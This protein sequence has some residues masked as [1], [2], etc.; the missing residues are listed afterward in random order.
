M[1]QLS[2]PVRLF[3]K[4]SLG[5]GTWRVHGLI[6]S[7]SAGTVVIAHS[8]VEGGAEITHTDPIR[9]NNSGRSIEQQVALEI[10]SRVKRQMDKGYKTT[11]DLALIGSTNQLGLVNPM[12]AQKLQDVT[13]RG[14]DFADAWLQPKYD[15]HRCLITKQGGEMLAYSRRGKPITTIPQILEDCDRWMQDGDT[16][17]GELYCHGEKL[18][19][20]S[21]WIKRDQPETAKL[22][23]HWYDMVLPWKFSARYVTMVDLAH[24]IGCHRI[25]L[26]P[27]VRAVSMSNSY[28]FFR[29]CKADK[30]EGAMLRLSIAGYEDAKRSNQL[31]KI[32]DREDCEVTVIGVRPSSQNWA[33]LRVRTDWGVEFDV[34]APGSLDE[35]T[36][37]LINFDRYLLKRLTVEYA[38]LT[39]ERVP[40]HCVAMRWREDV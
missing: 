37:V 33:I 13:I 9:T 8:S 36:K 16:L 31:L 15:G 11:R 21:S 40:F 4:N 3:R 35:K 1:S 32:K 19:T 6:E 10:N 24:N 2:E 29:E 39:A 20:I 28:A 18:Q 25:Q 38:M 23:Y 34:A 27:T 17:D 5:I 30:L 12:L 26:V 22:N 14:S 7:V